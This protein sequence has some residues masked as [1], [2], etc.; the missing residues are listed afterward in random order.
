M[1]AERCNSSGTLLTGA[2]R[3]RARGC[4]LMTMIAVVTAD[5][6]GNPLSARLRRRFNSRL[7]SAQTMMTASSACRRKLFDGAERHHTR[8]T[9]LA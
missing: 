9:R 3:W 7:I 4:A 1:E 8:V 6:G 5:G 2:V